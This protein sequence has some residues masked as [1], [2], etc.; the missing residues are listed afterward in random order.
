[1]S[2]SRD[3]VSAQSVSGTSSFAINASNMPPLA[4][5]A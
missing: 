4:F 1:M 2:A 3:V 5:R